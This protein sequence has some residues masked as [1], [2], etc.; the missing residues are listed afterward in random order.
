[1]K[2]YCCHKYK[3][4][5]YDDVNVFIKKHGLSPFYHKSKRTNKS[6]KSAHRFKAKTYIN[7]IVSHI[8]YPQSTFDY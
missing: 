1:M 6:Y 8:N 5:L 4:N 7:N 2:P 3:I